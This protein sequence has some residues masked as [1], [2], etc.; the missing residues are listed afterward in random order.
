MPHIDVAR[1]SEVH[2]FVPSS[3]LSFARDNIPNLSS[4]YSDN[5]NARNYLVIASTKA[6]GHEM[7]SGRSDAMYVVES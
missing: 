2:N 4:Q 3:D 6:R 5:V 1:V 7:L